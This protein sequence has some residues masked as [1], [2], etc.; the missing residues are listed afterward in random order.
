MASITI[1]NS[2]FTV[3]DKTLTVSY[4]T[5]VDLTGV[6]L[7]K[8]GITFITATNF[9]NSAAIFNV[10][11]W[12][13]GTYNNCYLRCSYTA[14]SGGGETTSD[15]YIEGRTLVFE[16]DFTNSSLDTSK[17]TQGYRRGFNPDS[18]VQYFTTSSNNLYL[19]NSNLVLKAIREDITAP[20]PGETTKTFNWTSAF[21]ET[22]DKFEYKYGRW[23]A[24]IKIPKVT[25]MF[26]AFWT[27]GGNHYVN[28][29]VCEYDLGVPWSQCGEIDI[30]EW[31]PEQGY[32]SS[33]LHRDYG[34]GDITTVVGTKQGVDD[35]YYNDYHIFAMEWTESKFEFFIDGVTTGTYD[36]TSSDEMFKW[37]HF[38][39]INLAL[40]ATVPSSVNE[41]YMYVD[42]V[43]V[44]AP[45]SG[46]NTGGD[47]PN[48]PE[49]TENVVFLSEMMKN[50]KIMPDGSEATETGAYSTGYVATDWA[51]SVDVHK[52][53]IEG[54]IRIAQYNTSKNAVGG[55]FTLHASTGTDQTITVSL[56]STTYY[57]RAFV[58]GNIESPSSAYIEFKFDSSGS[59][60]NDIN[61]LCSAGYGGDLSTGGITDNSNC[62]ATLA[63][64]DVTPGQTYKV[65]VDATWLWVMEYTGNGA[66]YV[67]H[68]ATLYRGSANNPDSC[69]FTPTTSY[70]RIGFF[71]P[72]HAHTYVTLDEI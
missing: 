46:D 7:T 16:D 58:S 1:A 14:S 71:D 20:I 53:G 57:V 17:W 68:N 54:G 25:G 63:T 31:V 52:V 2:S 62:Y 66:G 36:I 40:K 61:G 45:V 30:M 24:K 28:Y 49:D 55:D 5:D 4:T 37:E 48:L 65:T 38:M 6:E 11:N 42:W 10:S 51:T 43:R 3:T 50:V 72:N 27:M 69:T 34:S 8:D 59:T 70:I 35:S 21:V 39:M 56:S 60:S 15:A 47:D 41:I 19:E 9:S 22:I 44:Y 12:A 67:Y 13:N 29:G 18:E 32:F 64:I 33:N 26:P 23:E